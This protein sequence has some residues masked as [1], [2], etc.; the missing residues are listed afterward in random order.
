MAAIARRTA[1]A[2]LLALPPALR[3]D[4]RSELRDRVEQV[5]NSL[6]A[7]DPSDA[8]SVFSNSYKDYAKLRDYFKAL[9][10]A[11]RIENEVDFLDDPSP[12]PEPELN[13]R[14]TVTLA[15]PDT[16]YTRTRSAE[17]KIR[18]A[19]EK[20]KWKIA[21]FEPIDIFDPAFP[22]GRETEPRP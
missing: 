21:G 6:A 1:L 10:N 15:T 22:G 13:V 5:A 9:S 11:Y 17:I 16:N 18:F 3:A 14:W 7:G 4:E 12:G 2:L 19:R 8:I 20:S